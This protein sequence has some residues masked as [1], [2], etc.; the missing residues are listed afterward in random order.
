MNVD[1]VIISCSARRIAFFTTAGTHVYQLE[2]DCRVPVGTYDATVTVNPDGTQVTWT[3][4]EHEGT[5]FREQA[6]FRYRILAGQANP[7]ILFRNQSQVPVESVAGTEGLPA[8]TAPGTP[9]CLLT[10]SDR[11]ILARAR[12]MSHSSRRPSSTRRFG[13]IPFR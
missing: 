3:L 2:P 9:T 10:F 12:S 1:R 4:G 7:A 6:R 5:G 8:E 13:A 11:T